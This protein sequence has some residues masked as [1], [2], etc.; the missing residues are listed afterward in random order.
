[1][2]KETEEDSLPSVSDRIAFVSKV[3]G[4]MEYKCKSE[5]RRLASQKVRRERGRRGRSVPRKK[6]GGKNHELS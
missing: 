6:I 4:K 2:Y 3:E 1:M 5:F